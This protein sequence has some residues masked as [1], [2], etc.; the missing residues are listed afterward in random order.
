[1]LSKKQQLYKSPKVKDKR[2]SKTENLRFREWLTDNISL[3]QIC[4]LNRPQ[5]AHHLEWGCYGADKND[6]KQIAVCR[7]CHEYS[8]ANKEESQR[9]YMHIADENWNKYSNKI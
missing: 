4:G 3:C 9:L 5:D 8:H 6:K 2:L 1:M 7:S